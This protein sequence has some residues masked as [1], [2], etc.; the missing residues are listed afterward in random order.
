MQ[1]RGVHRRHH[2]ASHN[3]RRRIVQ[4]V[5]QRELNRIGESDDR[6]DLKS[7]EFCLDLSKILLPLLADRLKQLFRTVTNA[8]LVSF[9][10]KRPLE[11]VCSTK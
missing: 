6:F 11:C 7:D 4:C 9:E 1:L 10:M 8:L 2:S 3:H 5:V